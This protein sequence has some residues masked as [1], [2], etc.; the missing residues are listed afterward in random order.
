MLKYSSNAQVAAEIQA[1]LDPHSGVDKGWRRNAA[2]AWLRLS[3]EDSSSFESGMGPGKM[4]PLLA[5]LEKY[6]QASTAYN[7]I[8]PFAERL[9]SED[10]IQLV[11]NLTGDSLFG[12]SEKLSGGKLQFSGKLRPL[13]ENVSYFFHNCYVDFLRK[14]TQTWY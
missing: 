2:L 4:Q 1:H 10:R 12:D 11:R 13:H 7:D 14:I 6:G 9:A 8:R 3:F 5:Y